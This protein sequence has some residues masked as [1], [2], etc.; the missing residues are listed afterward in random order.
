MFVA[1]SS[2]LSSELNI[3]LEI[4]ELDES[5]AISGFNLAGL[6]DVARFSVEPKIDIVK[7]NMIKNLINYSINIKVGDYS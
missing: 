7:I 2:Y 5:V 3:K 1:F 6:V 4:D